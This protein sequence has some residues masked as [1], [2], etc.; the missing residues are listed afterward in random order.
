MNPLFLSIA[1][2]FPSFAFAGYICSSQCVGVDFDE[3]RI[4][5]IGLIEK[6]DP[7]GKDEVFRELNRKCQR[8][9]WKQGVFVPAYLVSAIKYDGKI[10]RVSNT[11]YS[12]EESSGW[13]RYD[14]WY[15]KRIEIKKWEISQRAM[16]VDLKFSTSAEACVFDPNITVP[17]YDG[18][19]PAEG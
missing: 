10:S 7:N 18:D 6:I 11:G 3:N 9:L 14:F 2:F 5:P 13:N 8:L 1:L 17:E 16:K 19:L 15:Y 4:Y 12:S